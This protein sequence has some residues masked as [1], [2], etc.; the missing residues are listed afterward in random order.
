[1]I[2]ICT[3]CGTIYD[4]ATGCPHCATRYRAAYERAQKRAHLWRWL[5]NL[6]RPLHR[7]RLAAVRS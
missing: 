7:V 6:W 1:M 2:E 5:R 4:T 3:D